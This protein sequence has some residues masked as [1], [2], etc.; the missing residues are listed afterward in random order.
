MSLVPLLISDLLDDIRRPVS[1]FDQNFG[2]GMLRDDLLS[3]SFVAPLRVGYYRPWRSQAAR[4]SGMSH[5]QDD[6]QD[7]KVSTYCSCLKFGCVIHDQGQ[8]WKFNN[9]IMRC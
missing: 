1:L 2:M 6:K 8:V 3:P 7:F 4:Q 5:I 9:F